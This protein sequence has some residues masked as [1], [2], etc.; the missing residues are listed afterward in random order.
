M[1]KDVDDENDEFGTP[2]PHRRRRDGPF[3]KENDN[4]ESMYHHPCRIQEGLHGGRGQPWRHRCAGTVAGG[5]GGGG[6][7]P[8][9][10]HPVLQC[11]ASPVPMSSEGKKN[12]FWWSAVSPSSDTHSS[13]PSRSSCGLPHFHFDCPWF[14]GDGESAPLS[15]RGRRAPSPLPSLLPPSYVSLVPQYGRLWEA[16][17]FH[18]DPIPSISSSSFLA[19][20]STTTTVEGRLSAILRDEDGEGVLLGHLLCLDAEVTARCLSLVVDV[21]VVILEHERN[22]SCMARFLSVCQANEEGGTAFAPPSPPPCAPYSTLY[23][24]GSNTPHGDTPMEAEEEEDALSHA[25]HIFMQAVQQCSSPTTTTTEKTYTATASPHQREDRPPTLRSPS[26]VSSSLSHAPPTHTAQVGEESEGTPM[27]EEDTAPWRIAWAVP[28]PSPILADPSGHPRPDTLDKK[29][30]ERKREANACFMCGVQE[31]TTRRRRRSGRE[32][33]EEDGQHWTPACLHHPTHGPTSSSSSSFIRTG[34]IHWMLGIDTALFREAL[35]VHRE[36]V[37][38]HDPPTPKQPC[39]RKAEKDDDEEAIQWDGRRPACEEEEEESGHPHS[40]LTRATVNA[41]TTAWVSSH[42]WLCGPIMSSVLHRCPRLSFRGTPSSHP[43]STSTRQKNKKEDEEK[44]DEEVDVLVLTPLL[45]RWLVERVYQVLRCHE[46]VPR[47]KGTPHHP[48]HHTRASRDSVLLPPQE[49]AEEETIGSTAAAA[50]LWTSG[51]EKGDE[52]WEGAAVHRL[53]LRLR[54][55]MC[56]L[57][58]ERFLAC[59]RCRRAVATVSPPPSTAT[60]P[61]PPPYHQTSASTACTHA[62]LCFLRD[63]VV[64]SLLAIPTSSSSS[65]GWVAKQAWEEGKVEQDEAEEG[66]RGDWPIVTL[67]SRHLSS[68]T[69][70]EAA[71]PPHCTLHD[72]NAAL[73]DGGGEEERNDALLVSPTRTPLREEEKS[74]EEQEV[75]AI[76]QDVLRRSPPPS[77]LGHRPT[78]SL[79]SSLVLDWRIT[80]FASSLCSAW[81][82]HGTAGQTI[83]KGGSGEEEGWSSSMA[84]RWGAVDR[85]WDTLHAVVF[86]LYST[87]LLGAVVGREEALPPKEHRRKQP[88]PQWAWRRRFSSSFSSFSSREAEEEA[89]LPVTRV[90]RVAFLVQ[91]AFLFL[92]GRH[93]AVMEHFYWASSVCAADLSGGWHPW[94]AAQMFGGIEAKTKKMKKKEEEEEAYAISRHSSSSS[95]S[96]SYRF[97]ES[98]SDP[99]WYYTP[100]RYAAH[101]MPWLALA[102]QHSLLNGL[103]L[104]SV[105]CAESIFYPSRR[106]SPLLLSSS[107]GGRRRLAFPSRVGRGSRSIR[108]RRNRQGDDTH[109]GGG[110]VAASPPTHGV[111]GEGSGW[112]AIS[113]H[114]LLGPSRAVPTQPLPPSSPFPISSVSRSTSQ[115]ERRRYLP[116]FRHLANSWVHSLQELGITIKTQRLQQVQTFLARRAA[117]QNGDDFSAST[118]IRSGACGD[119]WETP[120]KAEDGASS[121]STWIP[122]HR[123]YTFGQGRGPHHASS[124]APHHLRLQ[125]AAAATMPP[126]DCLLPYG[127]CVIA[128]ASSARLLPLWRDSGAPYAALRQAAGGGNGGPDATTTPAHT[129]RGMI[130]TARLLRRAARTPLPVLE[131][132]TRWV[133]RRVRPSTSSSNPPQKKKKKKKKIGKEEGKVG[134]HRRAPLQRIPVPSFRLVYPGRPSSTG[135]LE[136][137]PEPPHRRE[138]EAEE[139]RRKRTRFHTLPGGTTP[140]H[141]PPSCVAMTCSPSS[142][143]P[144][145]YALDEATVVEVVR[146]GLQMGVVGQRLAEGV[147]RECVDGQL[148]DVVHHTAPLGSSFSSSSWGIENDAKEEEEGERPHRRRGRRLSWS[149]CCRSQWEERRRTARYTSG[150]AIFQDTAKA[151][152]RSLPSPSMADLLW[153]TQSRQEWEGC[154]RWP[155]WEQ[156]TTTMQYRHPTCEKVDEPHRYDRHGRSRGVV[157]AFMA[158]LMAGGGGGDASATST[159]LFRDAPVVE[160]EGDGRGGMVVVGRRILPTAALMEVALT[161]LPPPTPHQPP[162]SSP[163]LSLSSSSS[164]SS[165]TMVPETTTSPSSIAPPSLSLSS[166]FAGVQMDVKQFLSPDVLFAV[167][168]RHAW[169]ASSCRHRGGGGG[170]VAVSTTQAI[171]GLFWFL[172]ER[173][174]ITNPP[175]QKENEEEEEDVEDDKGKETPRGRLRRDS[176]W[177]EE[178]EWPAEVWQPMAAELRRLAKVV[179]A[180]P[181]TANGRLGF[182]APHLAGD[183]HLSASLARV[184]SSSSSSTVLQQCAAWLQL[185]DDLTSSPPAPYMP[186]HGPPSIAVSSSSPTASDWSLFPSSDAPPPS[187]LRAGCLPQLARSPS[188]WV[189]HTSLDRPGRRPTDVGKEGET[190]R[191]SGGVSSRTP[192]DTA[193]PSVSPPLVLPTTSLYPSLLFAVRPPW[194]TTTEGGAEHP[195]AVQDLRLRASSS[196]WWEE[197]MVCA[198]TMMALPDP[199]A[200][201]ASSSSSLGA[202][203]YAT[204]SPYVWKWTVRLAWCI[205]VWEERHHPHHGGGEGGKNRDVGDAAAAVLPVWRRRR[206]LQS[207]KD[208]EDFSCT[209]VSSARVSRQ[210]WIEAT[211]RVLLFSHVWSSDAAAFSSSSPPLSSEGCVSV[212]SSSVTPVL[213]T[214]PRFI[215]LQLQ[216]WRRLHSHSKRHSTHIQKRE[217][218][219]GGGGRS[220][221]D[222]S[223]AAIPN[224]WRHACEAHLHYLRERR[225]DPFLSSVSAWGSSSSTGASVHWQAHYQRLHRLMI[226]WEKEMAEWKGFLR[227]PPSSSSATR[228]REKAEWWSRMNGRTNANTTTSVPGEKFHEEEEEEDPTWRLTFQSF[229]VPPGE[230]WC[231]PASFRN[232]HRRREPPPPWKPDID[233]V[234]RPSRGQTSGAADEA[235]LAAM[236]LLH[237]VLSPSDTYTSW[238]LAHLPRKN[239][240]PRESESPFRHREVKSGGGRRPRDENTTAR[241]PLPRRTENADVCAALFHTWMCHLQEEDS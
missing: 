128:A 64:W 195:T 179:M 14:H 16:I 238:L 197:W 25:W 161:E 211:L 86:Q 137:M 177:K 91:P 52:G 158:L 191:N 4:T 185:H 13:S 66:E 73:Q 18:A 100:L 229:F 194:R 207:H 206:R 12:V 171:A 145:V 163:P 88:F 112:S 219:D 205:G 141:P 174:A 55:A 142:A 193:S 78:V 199:F 172:Y 39:G 74:E 153:F 233:T 234:P 192:L 222:A 82:V 40:P 99:Q 164:S 76:L 10:H 97:S 226:E 69:S 63:A 22:T 209:V 32:D 45:R 138:D 176:R 223:M 196:G 33:E 134:R 120:E 198:A 214:F 227:D 44:E 202:S 159:S 237:A 186:L 29:K 213:H 125:A 168:Y 89:F 236:W 38:L 17:Y 169:S 117:Y 175:L 146:L 50:A 24:S 152:G 220:V 15:R 148:W 107:L 11:I 136:Q 231:S 47:P 92:L 190:N 135:R 132:C 131:P 123:R 8:H 102:A 139:E 1:G 105:L 165:R 154:F 103:L 51:Q 43:S 184:L 126:L 71:P 182:V 49:E 173:A 130:G 230:E 41:V 109:W 212:L 235:Y 215:A 27:A 106:R 167:Q 61:F 93:S 149:W 208:M 60:P 133:R 239:G 204:L 95:S 241:F 72:A 201:A 2:P 187:P 65:G 170:A 101:H 121:F 228:E 59:E 7:C 127:S 6:Y 144:L 143:L 240:S 79:F 180:V 119:E 85:A 83:R 46:T 111:R 35:L 200:R 98:I 140:S 216:L 224:V 118:A 178:W 221:T 181:P 34:S 166:L 122:P 37:D 124:A 70:D 30:E 21:A 156:R 151:T 218:E 113:W 28:V 62:A 31:T 58:H 19:E 232:R 160:R 81:A 188:L 42:D 48:H 203:L 225:G 217:E 36:E 115:A 150:M 23:Q 20:D 9:R 80:P 104:L 129:I 84:A 162:P 3:E 96:S 5:R 26:S 147:L 189:S 108:W 54:S 90:G 155:S 114:G 68:P 57:L 53:R 210:Q 67:V 116:V 87:L 77:P 183:R 56:H 110:G 94:T 75:D 157:C